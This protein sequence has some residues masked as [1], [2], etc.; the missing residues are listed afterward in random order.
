MWSSVTGFF[1]DSLEF[2]HNAFEPL[3]GVQSWGWAIIALTLI[4]RILLLPL[5]IKQ[6]RSMRK[7]Q[8]VGPKVKAI[9]KKY[10]A[11]RDLMKTNPEKYRMMKQ[12]MNEETMALYKAEGVNPAGGCVPLIAQMPVFFALF[13]VLR[14]TDRLEL[15]TAPFYFFTSQA[16][17]V[18]IVTEGITVTTATGGLGSATSSAG[19]AGII[20]ILA[21][22]ATMFITQRQML[23]RNA[24]TADSTQAQQ[25]KIMMYVMPV[26]LAVISFNLPLGVLLYWVT[27]NLWQLV[28]QQIMFRDLNKSQ[29]ADEAVTTPRASNRGKGTGAPGVKGGGAGALT[30]SDAQ[31]TPAAKDKS[32]SNGKTNVTPSKP[33]ANKSH[34]A[35]EASNAAAGDHAARKAAQSDAAQAAAGNKSSAKKRKKRHLPG[36]N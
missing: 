22:G 34:L 28:Q 18:D 27:T 7:M 2:L 32:S 8:E 17:P 11:D 4:T 24:A 3:F 23:G 30:N 9:Q 19:I 31:D 35:G 12:K 33:A 36:G 20:L 29:A 13:S 16:T 5:N 6:T 25:Q 26:F 1:A 10:K 15:V 21:M 14:S